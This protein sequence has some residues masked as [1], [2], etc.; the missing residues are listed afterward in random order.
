MSRLLLRF[1]FAAALACSVLLAGLPLQPAL[2]QQALSK[3]IDAGI[4]VNGTY[5]R[6]WWVNVNLDTGKITFS[7]KGYVD[8]PTWQAGKLSLADRTYTMD[9]PAGAG[10]LTWNA[11]VTALRDFIKTQAEFAGAADAT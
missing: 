4:G 3:T 6:I 10:A 8:K 5:W 7:V 11:L 1:I 2:A 9:I